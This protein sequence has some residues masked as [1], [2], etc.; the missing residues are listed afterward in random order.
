VDIFNTRLRIGFESPFSCPQQIFYSW[1]IFL[2][3]IFMLPELSPGEVSDLEVCTDMIPDKEQPIA[4]S[5][6]M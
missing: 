2:R 6:L 3:D 5:F 4:L 1:E